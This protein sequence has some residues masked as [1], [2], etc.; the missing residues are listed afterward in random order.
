MSEL[1]NGWVIEWVSEWV[2]PWKHFFVAGYLTLQEHM[3]AVSP[4][5]FLVFRSAPSDT[6][7]LITSLQ[8]TLTAQISAVSP[9]LF[10]VSNEAPLEI[11]H[12][13]TALWSPPMALM[14]AVSPILFFVSRDTPLASNSSTKSQSPLPAARTKRSFAISPVPCISTSLFSHYYRPCVLRYLREVP[15]EG[16]LQSSDRMYRYGICKKQQ[17]SFNIKKSTTLRCIKE[18]EFDDVESTKSSDLRSNYIGLGWKRAFSLA[19]APLRLHINKILLRKKTSFR[20][21]FFINCKSTNLVDEFSHL[22]MP[23]LWRM[24]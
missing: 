2:W 7:Y 18:T 21:P 3:S 14:S 23:S 22:T 16:P 9:P 10:L 19:S 24:H 5:L 8:P 6:K 20:I 13:I 12:S 11:K 15:L 17:Q 4:W 1:V